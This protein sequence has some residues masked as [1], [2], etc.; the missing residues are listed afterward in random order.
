MNKLK[1]SYSGGSLIKIK[2]NLLLYIMN[3]IF[4]NYMWLLIFGCE[5]MWGK[6]YLLLF[7]NVLFKICV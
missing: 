4:G 2:I 6:I 7:F 1:F 5:V 3:V